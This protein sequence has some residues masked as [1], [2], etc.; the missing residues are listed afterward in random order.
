MW[1][2]ILTI[3]QVFYNFSVYQN[4]FLWKKYIPIKRK[5]CQ[6]LLQFVFS[7]FHIT[8]SYTISV[9]FKT[10]L[11]SREDASGPGYPEMV[12]SLATAYYSNHILIR[13][14]ACEKQTQNY[15]ELKFPL[16]CHV[17]L[18]ILF[19]MQTSHQNQW[20][21]SLTNQNRWQLLWFTSDFWEWGSW[22]VLTNRQGWGENATI[23]E[24]FS[25]ILPQRRNS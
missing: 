11:R 2:G 16:Q 3:Y 21:W 6:N 10:T 24:R 7:W 17:P 19:L 13:I 1:S 18:N 4:Q 14:L 23:L 15:I 8:P 5:C 25:A 22:L 20:N 9:A 12:L